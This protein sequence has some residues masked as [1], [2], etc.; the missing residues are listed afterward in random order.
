MKAPS[1]QLQTLI[2]AGFLMGMCSLT[3]GQTTTFGSDNDGLGGFT[4]TAIDGTTTF[5]TENTGS[6]TY[7]NQ[8]TGTVD[9]G[10][11]KDFSSS[12]DRTPDTGLKYTVTGTVTINDGYADDNNRIDFVLFTDLTKVLS[13]DN[14]GQI[15]LV[16]NSDDS[17]AAGA[18]GNDAQD[19]LAIRNGWNTVNADATVTPVLRDQTIPYAQDLLQGTDVTWSATFWFTGTNINIDATMTDVGGVTSIGTATVLAADFTGDYFGFASSYRARNYDGSPDLTGA[20]R[21]NPL[22]MDYESF[23][24]SVIPEP[25]TLA[26][27]GAGLLYMTLRRRRK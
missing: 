19:N 17:S 8:N 23:S 9:A 2:A 18:P 14:L 21:D 16:W 22:V 7:R 4:H 27:L 20:T 24:L 11:I 26:L 3:F 25:S 13:R 1:K 10:F 5:L 15:G 12:I 6:V